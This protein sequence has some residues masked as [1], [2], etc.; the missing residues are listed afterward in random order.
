MSFVES[1]HEW[2][3]SKPEP[4]TTPKQPADPPRRALEAR[5]AATTAAPTA[6]ESESTPPVATSFGLPVAY[7]SEDNSGSGAGTSTEAAQNPPFDPVWAAID[8]GA[9]MPMVRADP[10][11]VVARESE[12]IIEAA[13]QTE[14]P[15]AAFGVINAALTD[16]VSE[17]VR[18]AV[19]EDERTDAILAETAAAV[20]QEGN[21]AQQLYGDNF[22]INAELSK[23]SELLVDGSDPDLAVALL[24]HTLPVLDEGLE[25]ADF[26][27]SGNLS[28]GYSLAA[29][30]NISDI[31]LQADDHGDHLENLAGLGNALLPGKDI[32]DHTFALEGG[33]SQDGRGLELTIEMARQRAA[34]GDDTAGL[35]LDTA[36]NGTDRF[37]DEELDPSFNAYKEH[38]EE[39]N[40][41]I[42]EFGPA[43]TP[44]QLALAIA[45]YRENQDSDWVDNE[46][47]LRADLGEKGHEFMRQAD[48]LNNLPPELAAIALDGEI[49]DRLNA[50][51]EEPNVQASV[52]VAIDERPEVLDEIDINAAIEF[53]DIPKYANRGYGVGTKAA[54]AW[55]ARN[56]VPAF[57]NLDP[58]DPTSV[59]TA[60]ARLDELRTTA[61]ASVFTRSGGL[62][63][64]NT[65]IDALEETLK[66]GSPEE[67]AAAQ[68]M[69]NAELDELPS[70]GSSTPT[71]ILFRGLGL[72]ASIVGAYGSTKDFVDDP[73][74]NAAI[75]ALVADGGAVVGVIDAGSDVGAFADDSS[76]VSRL[77][78][79]SPFGR[80]LGFAG[81]GL[82]TIGVIE[83]FSE[84][85][86]V[87]G[88][89]GA[90]GAGGTAWALFGSSTWAGPVGAAI[91]LT[92]AIGSVGYNQYTKVSKSNDYT[93][94]EAADFLVHAGFDADTA[95]ALTDRSGEGFSPVPAFMAYGQEQG[96]TRQQT[97]EWLNAMAP[98]TLTESR[99]LFHHQL[100]AVEGD[101]S[102]LE[103]QLALPVTGEQVID[104]APE[105]WESLSDAPGVSYS[106]RELV[107]LGLV[108]LTRQYD[109]FE[110]QAQ[111]ALE[112]DE[113]NHLQEGIELYGDYQQGLV[114][115][116]LNDEAIAH[117]ER[118]IAAWVNSS[119][120][121]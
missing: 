100:D 29:L 108:E 95:D 88:S 31:V 80:A 93:G 42:Q 58:T 17:D 16:D 6:A 4:D 12:E 77:G 1:F 83:D 41:Y 73:S 54:N 5:D 57:E 25:L 27:F 112:L 32:R 48:L 107:E 71:G 92:A 52:S 119:P 61:F 38:T 36:V 74:V 109:V 24:D 51:A 22:V 90:F 121:G 37:V 70:L 55:V 60:N 8:A 26:E 63:E 23:V 101:L 116:L 99:D 78:G 43:M 14:T 97:I 75:D 65:A 64:L 40:F 96:W 89:L 50:L 10:V 84:G 2:G 46:G 79:N 105:E 113:L 34:E 86:F 81:L 45:E 3:A 102:K 67:F 30:A 117:F 39:L 20:E 7:G 114:T 53:F 110:P 115:G 49:D 104:L 82:S 66:V 91:G 35:L 44:E 72:S 19:L 21:E 9:A 120:Y 47:A 94:E 69:L 76:L 56:V 18:A 33:I 111:N 62:D 118:Q 13:Q 87:N 98:D 85:D 28:G 11:V 103:D 59:R 106:T 15:E 68:A